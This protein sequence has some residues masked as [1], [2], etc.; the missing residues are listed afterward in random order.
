MTSCLW[1]RS[2]KPDDLGPKELPIVKEEE[3]DE[4]GEEEMETVV[5]AAPEEKWDCETIISE[6]NLRSISPCCKVCVFCS[7][8]SSGFHFCLVAN[9]C[10]TPVGEFYLQWW[11]FNYETNK[12]HD[13]TLRHQT[14]CFFTV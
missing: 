12:S 1:F 2:L 10:V 4:E 13:P 6:F 3:E 14:T 11:L 9:F 5:I 8:M 7:C